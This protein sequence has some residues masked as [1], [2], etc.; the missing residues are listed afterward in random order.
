MFQL[1]NV[2]AQFSTTTMADSK[3]DV[4]EPARKR[5][6]LDWIQGVVTLITAF[7]ALW[8]HFQQDSLK[9]KQDQLD[10]AMK[11]E[12]V[13]TLFTD[14]LLQQLNTLSPGDPNPIKGTIVLELMALDI[15]AHLFSQGDPE[16]KFKDLE[17]AC[18]TIPSR[19]A[20]FTSNTDALDASEETSWIDY[21]YNTDNPI[22]RHTAL[23]ALGLKGLRPVAIST[24][25][26]TSV[27]RPSP[28]VQDAFNQ[29]S[30][31]FGE[32]LKLSD[33]LRSPDL[34]I[35]ALDAISKLVDHNRD[36]SSYF[37]G[38]IV[39]ENLLQRIRELE[40]SLNLSVGS[41]DKTDVE[42]Q[43]LTQQLSH[44]NSTWGTLIATGFCIEKDRQIQGPVAS[45]GTSPSP[46]QNSTPSADKLPV[47]LAS[48]LSDRQAATQSLNDSDASQ[49]LD[50]LV[51]L[52]T[53]PTTNTA[54]ARIAITYALYRKGGATKLPSDDKRID[55]LL[56]LLGD[57]EAAVRKNASEFLM[58]LW[59]PSSISLIH[60][61]LLT[62]IEAKRLK[63]AIT[64]SDENLL[65]NSVLV[66]GTW[67][68]V[69]PD[70]ELAE[71]LSIKKELND[72]SSKLD[73]NAWQH[74]LSTIKELDDLAAHQA[75][76]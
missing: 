20:L 75:T 34:A 1:V 72:L 57:E 26:A 27:N 7:L 14:K 76:G 30:A 8:I 29:L 55:T 49:L 67:M 12:N 21:A 38:T 40:S 16:Q 43:Q 17:E 74:T 28:Q 46:I 65:F 68:R 36:L 50:L 41:K 70:S 5:D 11:K 47:Q 64:K 23:R 19:V 2:Q 15:Q 60:H 44:L 45:V 59:D 31:R 56:T 51:A 71:K 62:L 35:D 18:K 61:K 58:S 66:L 42:K 48:N 3:Q 24:V 33:E 63:P 22:A 73:A 32:I 9:T 54:S 69:L 39:F 53:T 25:P 10:L 4:P 13:T 6:W 37:R 52:Q